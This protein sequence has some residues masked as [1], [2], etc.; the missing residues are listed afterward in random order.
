MRGDQA[1]ARECY[2]TS[3]DTEKAHQTLM[4][5]G[6]RNIVEPLEVMGDIALVTGDD[7]K[8]TM[9]RTTLSKEIRAELIN[10]LKAN[11]DV[12][13]WTKRR[14]FAPERNV[15]VMEEV[16]KLLMTRFIREVYYPEWLANVVMVKKSSGKWRM[17]VDFTDLNKAC[18]KDSYPLPRIDQLVDSTIVG[19]KLLSF[20][21]T[22]SSYNQMDEADQEKTAFITSRGLFCYKVMPFGL[23]NVGAM[24][25]RLS[26]YSKGRVIPLPSG[27]NHRCEFRLDKRRRSCLEA[28]LLHW[29]IPQ[30]HKRMAMN[31]PDTARRL[32]LWAIEMIEFDVDYRPRTAIKA[33][34]LAN[35]IAE[36]THLDPEKKWRSDSQ[37]VVG[38]VRGEYEAREER[39]KKYLKLIQK[40]LETLEKVDFCHIPREENADADHLTRLASSGEEGERIIE[41]Q[42]RPSI[43]TVEVS[44]IF[45]GRSWMTD[46]IQYLKGGVG[47][48]DKK[49]AHKLRVRAT[50]F[51]LLRDVLYKMGFSKPYLRCLAPKDAN[52]VLRE[53]HEGIC[54]NHSGA[55][56]LVHKL[57]RAGYFWPSTLKDAT[58]YTRLEGAKGLW[59]EELPSILWV[60]TTTARTPTKETLFKL[61]FGTE[62]II[63]VEIGM[64]GFRTAHYCEGKNEDLLRLNLNLIDKRAIKDPFQGKLGPN[65]EGP[66]KVVQYFRKG[67]YHLEDMG[68]KKLPHP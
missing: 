63:P 64:T 37:L 12:F 20:M 57:T 18:P 61:T 59:V 13:A 40:I 30:R 31:K 47:P 9:I 42:G 8:T 55:R 39:M 43:E 15:A 1:M 46:I 32:V 22:F 45:N 14:V 6:R 60:Y 50:R 23:K 48:E 27:I 24:Y 38:Q 51:V 56:A 10:F 34:A 5:E 52:Y 66:Y 21:D 54:G 65:W 28:R 53:V 49:E 67:T 36:F 35:F 3:V 16:E 25:Q 4:V 68:G 41:V 58:N 7:K 62:A 11:A 17:C 2:L 33:Q 26:F 19:H 44:P 29:T